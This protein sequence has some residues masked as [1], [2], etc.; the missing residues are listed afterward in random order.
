[1]LFP[2]TFFNFCL[3]RCPG[4]LHYARTLKG[5][6]ISRNILYGTQSI[7]FLIQVRFLLLQVFQAGFYS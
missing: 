1:M 6:Y 7:M 5:T 2:R 4:K 3:V